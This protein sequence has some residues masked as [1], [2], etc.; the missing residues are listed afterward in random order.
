VLEAGGDD[1]KVGEEVYEVYTAP[2]AFHTV[3]DALEKAGLKPSN[4]ELAMIPQSPV[5]IDPSR[6]RQLLALIEALDDHDD[7]Q[8][9]AANCEL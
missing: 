8:Q 1:L 2:G 5:T 4:A 3:R 9:V 7:V 6:Q